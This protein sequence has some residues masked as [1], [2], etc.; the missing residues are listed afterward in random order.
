LVLR[1]THSL[2]STSSGQTTVGKSKDGG[3]GTSGMLGNLGILIA[4]VGVSGNLID[5]PGSSKLNSGY[6]GSLGVGGVGIPGMLGN[7]GILIVT[8]GVSGNLI[9]EPGSSKLN[10]GYAGS[11]GV[12]GVGIPGMLGN[13]GIL[14]VTTGGFGKQDVMLLSCSS[15]AK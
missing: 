4:I 5:E 12:G 3:V 10:S 2:L 1:L 8:T 9:D 6:S 14:I 13:P 7:P 15:Q 11:L